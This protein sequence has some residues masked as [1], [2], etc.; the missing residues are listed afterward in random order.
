MIPREHDFVM[1]GSTAP[2]RL[3]RVAREVTLVRFPPGWSR[4]ER[5]HYLAG[6]QF[7]VLEGSL[8]VSGNVYKKGD[9]A[10]L[11]A[12]TTRWDCATEEGALALAVFDGPPTW[13]TGDGAPEEPPKRGHLGEA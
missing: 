8:L 6:E 3:V 7:T 11:P 2:V 10:W 5:G 4:P 12:G 9:W 1:P 13:V